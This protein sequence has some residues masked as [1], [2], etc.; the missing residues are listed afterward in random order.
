MFRKTGLLLMLSLIICCGLL[1][2]EKS[3]ERIANE[4]GVEG[5][6]LYNAG[7]YVEAAAKFEEAIAKLKEAVQTDGIPMDKDKIN[8]WWLYAFNG[9]FQG[10]DYENAIKALDARLE[11][12]PGSWDLI[13]YKAIILKSKLNR[14]P[15]AI[16]VLK[17]YNANKRSFKVEKKIAGYYV[18]MDDKEKALEWYEKAYELKN[19]SKVIKNIATLYVQLGNNAEA[20]KAYEDFLQTNPRES[21]LIQ[22]YKNMGS[23]YEDMQQYNKSNTYFEKALEM[24]YD[25]AIN[26]LLISNYYDID[27]Y[28]KALEKIDQR[29]RNSP[30]DADAIYFRAMIKYNRGNKVGAKSDFEKLFGSKYDKQAKGF[31]ESIESEL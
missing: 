9:Y 1:F 4:I 31:V 22:T 14:I 10:G 29:L 25:S 23:L 18:D 16:E 2:A 5:E 27:K 30:G 3:L 13:N 21:V 19:D 17:A 7:S 8:Q 11:L 24:K 26:L 12:N 20:V 6:T 15:E 28:D